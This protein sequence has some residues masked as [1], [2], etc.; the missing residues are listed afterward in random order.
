MSLPQPEPQQ[1]ANSPAASFR[2]VKDKPAVDAGP[3]KFERRRAPRHAVEGRVTIYGLADTDAAQPP[4]A[5]ISWLDL[6]NRSAMG[7]CGLTRTKFVH[8]AVVTVVLP[9]DAF[10]TGGPHGATVARCDHNG[11]GTYTLGLE[12]MPERVHAA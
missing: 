7:L 4:H 11:D 2:L 6:F 8:G 9:A 12:L 1:P 10:T 5:H 3:I